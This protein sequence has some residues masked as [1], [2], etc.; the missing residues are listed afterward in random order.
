LFNK[1]SWRPH[2]DPAGATGRGDTGPSSVLLPHGHA[3]VT[4]LSPDIQRATI[5]SLLDTLPPADVVF[6]LQK[7]SG[8]GGISQVTNRAKKEIAAES[9]VPA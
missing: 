9:S 7:A 4:N 6:V 8:G 2:A 1:E 3:A 5:R